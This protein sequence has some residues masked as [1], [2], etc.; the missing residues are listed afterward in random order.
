MSSNKVLF[1]E[2]D[3]I[4]GVYIVKEGKKLYI[5]IYKYNIIKKINNN[6]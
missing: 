1:N 4:N 6:F 3:K 5:Y 2:N